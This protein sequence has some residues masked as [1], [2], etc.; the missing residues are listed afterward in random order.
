M[1][2]LSYGNYG[3]KKLK[4]VALLTAISIVAFPGIMKMQGVVGT[5]IKASQNAKKQLQEKSEQLAKKLADAKNEIAN[6]VNR[7]DALDKQISIVKEQ[8]DVSNKYIDSLNKEIEESEKNIKSL[9]ADKVKKMD[10]LKVSLRSIYIA[11][12][13]STIDIVLGAKTFEE[14]LDKAQMVKT[15]STTISSLIDEL[16]QCIESIS[17]QKG[18]IEENRK[19]AEAEYASLSSKQE[20]LQ[21]LID[22]S[23]VILSGLHQQESNAKDELDENDSELKQIEA[24]I[25]AYYE[26]Q[27]RKAEQEARRKAAEE[28][29]RRKQQ[30]Q[31]QQ[32]A[33]NNSNNNNSNGN[34][35]SNN[36]NNNNTPVS[37]GNYLWPVPGYKYI[38]SDFFDR[39]GRTSM[40]GAIDIAGAK[41]YGAKI[42]AVADGKVIQSNASGWGGGYG[43]YLTIDHGNGRSTLY[44]HMSGITVEKG[45]SVKKGQVIGYVGSTGH[46]TGP[47]LHFETRLYGVKYNPMIEFGN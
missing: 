30:Q 3:R 11:G 14:F 26:E 36:N 37:T 12:D 17:E 5:D 9:E 33:N 6:E 23:E 38:S 10:S 29:Q 39:E 15:V 21:G 41:I 22:E 20:E 1:A 47:H 25:N 42:V 27:K 7:K 2:T 4:G 44:A 16:N 13:T 43:T 8:I 24:E 40:H 31:Q 46:S 35:N 19:Q 45:D 32:Q 28:E 34:S 18:I